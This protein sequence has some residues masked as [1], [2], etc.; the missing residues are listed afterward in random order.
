MDELL[1]RACEDMF[2]RSETVQELLA[3]MTAK[4]KKSLSEN[5]KAQNG[6]P[7]LTVLD[8]RPTEKNLVIADMQKVSSVY[9]KTGNGVTFVKE[10]EVL[11]AE[12]NKT[13]KLLRTIGF[14]AP[15]EL[16][17]SGFIGSIS[18]Q[19]QNVN[20]KGEPFSK[21]FS[22]KSGDTGA[23]ETST[24]NVQY[25]DREIVGDSG[26]KY[27]VGVYLDSNIFE[28]LN[29]QER[30]RA[31]K[32]F[33]V[34]NLAGKQITAYDQR[35]RPVAIGIAEKGALIKNQQGKHRRVLREL[36]NKNIDQTISRKQWCWR[37]S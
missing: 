26:T 27:G 24:K 19:G 11:Y 7:V 28:G 33:V 34:E 3:K 12:K 13:A 9:S 1:A 32:K 2:G 22:E 5:I 37:M 18:Y 23:E 29:E 20:M 31:V 17:Q 21:V 10:S 16:Q 25:S 30:M 4:E 6:K 15:I 36:Y 8:L 35:N 14:L